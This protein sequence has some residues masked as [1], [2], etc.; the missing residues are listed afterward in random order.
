VTHHSC[1]VCGNPIATRE[2]PGNPR[3]YCS[4]ACRTEAYRERQAQS[5]FEPVGEQPNVLAIVKTDLAAVVESVLEDEA[6]APAEEQ[7]ARAVIETQTLATA[8]RRL[9]PKL[10]HGLSWRAADMGERINNAIND[11]FP[12]LKDNE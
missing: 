2:R 1:V 5:F 7:L 9:E 8:Y 12:T 4:A 6:S 10:P 11:L 3:R